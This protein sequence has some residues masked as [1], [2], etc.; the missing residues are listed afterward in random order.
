VGVVRDVHAVLQQ[1]EVRAAVSV[2]RDELAVDDHTVAELEGG[3]LR[4]GAG[5]VPIVAAI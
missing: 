1:T 5:D 4:V 2:E 3:D